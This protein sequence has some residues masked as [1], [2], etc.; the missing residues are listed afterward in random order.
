MLFDIRYPQKIVTKGR[1]VYYTGIKKGPVNGA[2]QNLS[3][4][5]RYSQTLSAFCSAGFD[6][7]L[8][9]NSRHPFPESVFVFPFPVRWLKC[10]F[11]FMLNFGSAKIDLFLIITNYFAGIFFKVSTR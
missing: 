4:F 11:H 10:S 3:H 1:I 9:I 6:N 8:P 2:F 7:L 5:I